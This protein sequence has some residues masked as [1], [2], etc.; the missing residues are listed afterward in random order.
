MKFKILS[1][2]I[3]VVLYLSFFGCEENDQTPPELSLVG[4]TDDF[5]PTVQGIVTITAEANDNTGISK[6]EFIIDDTLV[7]KDTSLPYEYE[8]HTSEYS[9]CKIYTI[10]VVAYDNSLNSTAVEYSVFVENQ[11]LSEINVRTWHTDLGLDHR[12][13][14]LNDRYFGASCSS[15]TAL[16][17]NI[18]TNEIYQEIEGFGASLTNSSAWLIDNSTRRDEIIEKLFSPDSGIGISYIRLAM[19]SSDFVEGSHYSYAE[20]LDDMDLSDFSIDRDRENIIP[21]LQ[22]ILAINPDLKIMGSPWSAPGWMKTSGQFVCGGYGSLKKEM[23]AVYADYFVKFIEEYALEGIPI[24]AITIQN[25]PLYC[26]WNYPGMIMS[27]EEQRDFVK[28]YLGPKFEENG[29]DTKIVI[30]DHN[31]DG[32][33]D[34]GSPQTGAFDFIEAVYD[35]PLAVSY[36]DGTAFHGYDTGNASF[37]SEIYNLNPNKSIYFTERTNITDWSDWAGVLGHI[38]K[39]YFIDVLRYWSKNVLLWNLA[40]DTDN[41]PYNGGCPNCTGVVTVEGDYFEKE[42]DYYIIG[43]F[44]KFVQQSSNRIYSNTFEGELETVAF[45]NPDG[46]LVVVTLNPGWNTVSYK[47]NWNDMYFNHSLSPQSM[48]TFVWEP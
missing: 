15:P 11:N 19:G 28:Y 13:E 6:I 43:H 47:I 7:F 37:Q 24:D 23:Y 46:S 39:Y 26:P 27:G 34:D 44:S 32:T 20:T 16:E 9:N 25:E 48:A 35:D 18:S 29:I 31:W 42:I 36:I 3:S 45:Q 38:A 4:F 12:L 5:T 21:V 8:W 1:T 14:Q 41:G 2:F 33:W 17:V 30:F 10:K 40:L 22:D